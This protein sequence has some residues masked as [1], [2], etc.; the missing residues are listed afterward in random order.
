MIEHPREILGFFDVVHWLHGKWVPD[1]VVALWD[2]PKRHNELFH[3]IQ[4]RHIS[5]G[6]SMKGGS[7]S[8]WPYKQTL[9]R[10]EREGVIKRIADNPVRPTQVTYELTPVFREFMDR[11]AGDVIAWADRF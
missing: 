11:Y 10:L 5:H 4:E 9:E 8:K 1:V 6:W 3:A 7:L 2:G